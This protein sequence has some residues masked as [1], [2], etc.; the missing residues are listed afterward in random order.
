LRLSWPI[1]IY[2]AK[3][4]DQRQWLG[5]RGKREVLAAKQF[6]DQDWEDDRDQATREDE[7]TLLEYQVPVWYRESRVQLRREFEYRIHDCVKM[8]GNANPDSIFL[9]YF[10]FTINDP[11]YRMNRKGL[12]NILIARSHSRCLVVFPGPSTLAESASQHVRSSR[13]PQI[14]RYQAAPRALMSAL[15]A[16]RL[17]SLFSTSVLGTG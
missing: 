17:L 5:T 2:L 6:V 8:A 1:Q 15:T 10:K 16:V 12:Q 7:R 13:R 3:I 9:L 4:A 11:T 14:N